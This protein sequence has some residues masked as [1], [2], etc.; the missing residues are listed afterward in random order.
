MSSILHVM[1]CFPAKIAGGRFIYARGSGGV[2]V[3]RLS[4][5]AIAI[6]DIIK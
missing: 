1:F 2:T 5:F 3:F 4:R 6:A